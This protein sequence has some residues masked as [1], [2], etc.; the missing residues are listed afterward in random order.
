MQFTNIPLQRIH[1]KV[2]M[3]FFWQ[4]LQKLKSVRRGIVFHL[5]FIFN[6]TAVKPLT[7]LILYYFMNYMTSLIVLLLHI[8]W[9]TSQP[10]IQHLTCSPFQ[11]CFIITVSPCTCSWAFRSLLPTEAPEWRFGAGTVLLAIQRSWSWL[12]STKPRSCWIFTV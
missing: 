10:P 12:L 9:M 5:T 11:I 8:W 7:V 1:Y 4:N 2:R 6:V 3:F